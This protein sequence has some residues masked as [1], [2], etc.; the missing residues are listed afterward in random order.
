VSGAAFPGGDLG[1]GG[2]GDL[3]D[4]SR[5]LEPSGGRAVPGKPFLRLPVAPHD[6]YRQHPA[7]TTALPSRSLQGKEREGV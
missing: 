6:H 4:L 2:E 3:Q 1:G 5:V 7:K